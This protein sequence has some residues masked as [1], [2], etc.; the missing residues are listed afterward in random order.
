MNA[1][2]KI[3]RHQPAERI[4]GPLIKTVS[5]VECSYYFDIKKAFS[6]E[7]DGGTVEELSNTLADRIKFMECANSSPDD[8]ESCLEN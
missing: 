7:V 2:M 1:M 4:A 6:T 3:S 5:K 8:V